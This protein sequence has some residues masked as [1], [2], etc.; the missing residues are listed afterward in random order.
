M[1]K[2]QWQHQLA[3]PQNTSTMPPQLQMAATYAALNHRPAALNPHHPSLMRPVNM[4]SSGNVS[5][6]NVNFPMLRNP[7]QNPI[8]GIEI[9][10]FCY[11]ILLH[12]F[13]NFFFVIK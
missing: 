1:T 4:G 8:R 3:R 10:C 13:Y 9:V 5:A 12:I 6:P 2:F 7:V 11:F